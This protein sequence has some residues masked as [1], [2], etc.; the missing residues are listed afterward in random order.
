MKNK[1]LITSAGRKVSLVRAFKDAGW[2]VTGQ[3]IDPNAVAL[4]FCD[5]V[6]QENTEIGVDMILATSDRELHMGSHKPSQE[7]LD[8]CLDKK[9]FHD[10][11]MANNFLTPKIYFCKPR[12]SYSGRETEMVYQEFVEGYKEYSIDIFNSFDGTPINVV[13]RSRDKIVMGESW[14]STTV[15]APILIEEAI[16]L[17]LALKLIGHSVIQCFWDG[18]N[19]PIMLECNARFGGQSNLSIKAGCNSP[20]YLLKLI[21]REEVKP[22]IGNYIRNIKVYSYREDLIES[23]V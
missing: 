21:N 22:E 23:I 4:K 11:C 12:I 20:S 14:V 19:R 5:E 17:S 1:V 2:K 15:E 13:P 9:K 7:T 3:D 18:I 8:I 10:F 6:A 16:K